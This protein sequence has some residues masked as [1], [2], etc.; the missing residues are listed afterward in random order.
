[1]KKI[2]IFLLS[3][4]PIY[5][6]D[7]PMRAMTPS[8]II[9]P[10]AS[11]E[12][13]GLY[14]GLNFGWAFHGLSDLKE[15]GMTTNVTAIRGVRVGGQLGYDLK[16]D[17]II[18]GVFADIGVGNVRGNNYGRASE[19]ISIGM[20]GG[21]RGRLG[22][23]VTDKILLY[24]ATGIGYGHVHVTGGAA[25]YNFATHRFGLTA[26]GGGEYRMDNSWSVFSEYRYTDLGRFTYDTV[27]PSTANYTGHSVRLGTNYRF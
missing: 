6:A 10:V 24:G 7:I 22:Y 18:A 19:T 11:L 23:L 27:I 9:K 1:M 17:R 5:A 21:L 14:A 15:P 3:I 25:G 20:H 8:A 12:W 2:L 26:G 16:F 4:T 13:G